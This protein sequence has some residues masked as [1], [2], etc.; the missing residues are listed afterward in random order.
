MKKTIIFGTGDLGKV[1]YF[2]LKND[3]SHEVVAFTANNWAIKEEKMFDLP[4]VPFE[5]IESSY[6]PSE[7]NMFIAIPYTKMN[8][9][10]EKIYL[11]SKR[12]G[13]EFVTYINS[14]AIRWED[15]QI[16]ENCFIL[17][18]NVI[19]PFVK[20]GNDVIIWSGNHIG[21]HSEIGDHSFIASHVVISGKV[22]IGPNCFLG[23]N[24]TIRDGIRIAKECVIGAGTVILEDTEEKGVYASA[25]S[26]KLSITSDK[27]KHL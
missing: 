10:R 26:K 17:E 2:Y 1:V 3:S 25:S 13:Y 7:Y 14:K 15:L 24:S 20:I 6:P 12:K 22:K 16:G 21:H 19:Q 18:N 27:L 9:I 4:V 5:Q 11:E 23:V 8:K